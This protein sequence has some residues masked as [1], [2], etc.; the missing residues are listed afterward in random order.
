[1]LKKVEPAQPVH[2]NIYQSNAYTKDVLEKLAT[3][4]R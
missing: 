2:I 1:M 4:S 3:S